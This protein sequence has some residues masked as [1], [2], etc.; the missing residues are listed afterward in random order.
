MKTITKKYCNMKG[1][2]DSEPYEVIKVVSDKCLEIRFMKSE[3]N[4]DYNPDFVAGG[5]SAHCTNNYDQKWIITSCPEAKTIRVRKR[6]TVKNYGEGVYWHQTA[7]YQLADE[8]HKFYD[9]NF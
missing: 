3:K 5:F 8:P 9:Y 6:K 7:R 2:T 1:W 4:P